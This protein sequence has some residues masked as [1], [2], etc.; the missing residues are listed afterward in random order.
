MK[1]LSKL[2]CSIKRLHCIYAAVLFIFSLLLVQTFGIAPVVL[3]ASANT[4][5]SAP[6]DIRWSTSRYCTATWKGV[7]GADFY[8]VSLYHNNVNSNHMFF[9]DSINGKETYSA[10][11]SDIMNEF[12]NEQYSFKV[13]AGVGDYDDD[14]DIIYGDY[15]LMSDI[16]D[17]DTIDES[18]ATLVAPVDL[19]WYEDED[20]INIDYYSNNDFGHYYIELYKNDSVYSIIYDGE[21]DCEVYCTRVMPL[22]EC[23]NGTYKFRVLVSP[24]KIDNP[25]NAD[26][27]SGL[28]SVFSNEYVISNA[29]EPVNA[30]SNIMVSDSGILSF[31]TNNNGATDI[32]YYLRFTNPSGLV[33]TFTLTNVTYARVENFD[34]SPEIISNGTYK[35]KIKAARINADQSYPNYDIGSVSPEFSFEVNATTKLS[36]PD[37]LHWDGITLRWNSIPDAA[38]YN[39]QLEVFD[40]QT[41]VNMYRFTTIKTNSYTISDN[42]YSNFK[43]AATHLRFKARVMAIPRNIKA[44]SSS[45]YSAYAEYIVPIEIT[46]D[47]IT[48]S[49]NSLVCD[50]TPKEPAI[51]VKYNNETLTKGVDYTVTYS[52][53]IN[54]GTASATIK[55]IDP[56]T[57]SVTV[58][59][60]ITEAV[61]Q[62]EAEKLHP[63][64]STETVSDNVFEITGET[65]VSY[66]GTTGSKKNVTIPSSTD[67]DGKSYAV[68]SI[69]KNAFK[70]EK[71]I[72]KVTIPKTVTKISADAFSGCKNLS[73]IYINGNTLNSIEKGAFNNIKKN[74]TI[75]ITAKNKKVFN[76][77][78]KKIKKSTNVKKLKFK[79]KKGK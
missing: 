71:G 34:L 27:E 52:N 10:N 67:I 77:I 60:S 38:S 54:V 3:H 65:S 64:G 49:N 76:K 56:F 44:V 11:L 79:M 31:D 23:G 33:T 53:N 41:S 16:Y 45:G 46:K 15:S 37:S 2:L 28:T 19:S 61:P 39:V 75:T 66:T 59:Y 58:N 72:S 9:V 55:G 17:E 30:P 29:P 4:S 69:G 36:S 51:T 13:R 5:L 57:G 74:A 14:D 42:Y 32:N 62:K 8:E 20:G 48:L 1:L 12:P 22:N 26:F 24:T 73:K 21:N 63:I 70:D 43:K 50:G 47:M 25:S 78:V 68:T 35:V 6:T 40:G 7:N 18:T